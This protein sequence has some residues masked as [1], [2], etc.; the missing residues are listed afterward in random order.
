MIIYFG[1]GNAIAQ[2]SSEN[3]WTLPAK[4]SLRILVVFGEVI[5]DT[6]PE[7]EFIPNGNK[8][9]PKGSLPTYADSLFDVQATSTKAGRVTQYYQEISLGNLKVF[10]DYH[11]GLIQIP[12][13]KMMRGGVNAMLRL[14]ADTLASNGPVNSSKGYTAQDFDLWEKSSGRGLKILPRTGD[15]QGVDHVMVLIRN[16]HVLGGGSGQ[17]SPSSFGLVE[18]KR[19]DSYSVFAGGAGFPF[20]ILRHELNHLFLGG[21]NFHSGGG[22]SAGFTS[23]VLP[24]QGGWSMMGGANS[25][26]ITCSGWDR[27][28][29][30]WIADG[31]DFLISARDS[32]GGE[33]NSDLNAS[34]VNDAGIYILRDFQTTGDALRIKLP[35]IP[36]GEFQQWLWLENHT[37]FR[38][39]GSEFDQFLH[40]AYDCTSYS[41]SGIYMQMQLD[42][43]EKEGGNIFTK[44]NA[45]Y[46]RPVLANG[47]Y[48]LLWSAD[49]VSPG[50]CVNGEAY[51]YYEQIPEREN[52]LS[53]SH[54]QE[55]SLAVLEDTLK[56]LDHRNLEAT[57]IKKVDG[58]YS[59]LPLMGN[60]FHAFRQAGNDG[61]GIGTNPTAASMLTT[62]NSRKPRKSH[63]KNNRAVHLNGISIK[64]IETFPDGMVKVRIK[65]DDNTLEDTRRWCAPEIVLHNHN[66]AGPDL[67]ITGS[68]ILSRGLTPTRLDHPDSLTTTPLFTD[69]TLMNVTQDALIEVDHGTIE[70]HQDSELHFLPGSGLK[71]NRRSS[72]RLKDNSEVIFHDGAAFEGRGRFRIA[73]GCTIR[74][75]DQHTR[76]AVRSRTCQKKRVILSSGEPD[77]KS[78]P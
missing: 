73:K 35:Y 62:V 34:S 3:G 75:A 14:M 72:L 5:Y 76:K 6:L 47:N 25:S 65:F 55:I 52:P 69:R 49:K 11:P 38:F 42:A 1:G 32:I 67:L 29:L 10:G 70:L 19:T 18:G 22:N 7:L 33:I 8:I 41:R 17:A 63:E 54:D 66:M 56:Q 43:E 50:F 21:N 4:D 68:L 2:Q 40:E 13:S 28:R 78:A 45:D 30:G 77:V 9:W 27:Y 58:E 20:N 71:H 12:Y 60:E 51:R 36:G 59:R 46:L 37:T 23:Y 16:Y 31:N 64:I 15:F 26:L 39:N 53:G 48:D 44:V 74:C 61:L 57:M 24:V